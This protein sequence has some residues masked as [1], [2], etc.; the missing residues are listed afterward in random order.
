MIN[1][2]GWERGPP[3][4]PRIRHTRCAAMPYLFGVYFML[5]VVGGTKGTR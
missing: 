5:L 3:V 4:T 1:R 2:N